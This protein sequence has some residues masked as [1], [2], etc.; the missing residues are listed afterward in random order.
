MANPQVEHLMR[1]AGF[2]MSP[3]ER[4]RLGDFSVPL[5]ID[6]LLDFE[7][8]DDDVDGKIGQGAYV[9]I[10]TR[11]QF[12]PY[13]NIEDARQRWLFRMVHSRRPLEEKMALFWHNHFAT[14][15]SKIAGVVGGAQATKM[16]ALKAGELPG[17]AGQVELFRRFALGNFRDLLVEMSRDPAMLVWLD[18]RLNTRQRPQENFGR[19]VME[20]FTFGVGNYTEQDVYAAAR[21]FTGWGIRFV[22]NGNDTNSYYEVVYN[23]N[24]HEAT[25]KTF[26]FPIYN[27]GGRTIP[28]RAPADGA[29]DVADFITALARHPQTARRLAAKLWNF[30]ISEVDAPDEAFLRTTAAVYLQN[31]TEMRP[32]V[33]SVLRSPWFLERERVHARYSWP[34]EFVVRAIKETGWTGFSIDTTRTPLTNMGQTLFEPPDVNGWDLGRGWFSTG[35]MLARMNF[36]STLAANQRFNLARDAGAFRSSPERV[37]AYFMSRFTPAP[38]DNEPYAELLAYLNAGGSWSGSDAQV[39]A[40]AAGLARLIVGSSEYQFV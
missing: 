28:A 25:A 33:R 21:V 35:A 10:T 16:M 29:Q 20:L 30:F 12:S 31:N 9:S 13:T 5:L 38:F 24:N 26:T 40:R 32:V 15:Y 6:M 19:E 7:R 34:V 36:A 23:A 2:G 1:R 8:A 11:G 4:A 3:D 18:G 22:N 14:A 17:A 39:N 27:D 37:M